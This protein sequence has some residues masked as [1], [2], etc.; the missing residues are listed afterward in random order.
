MIKARSFDKSGEVRGW[1]TALYYFA[2]HVRMLSFGHIN[3][4]VLY[5]FVGT[6]GHYINHENPAIR[7]RT[8]AVL[9][10]LIHSSRYAGDF[11]A[12]FEKN[13]RVF[14]EAACE[15]RD[16]LYVSSGRTPQELI[17]YFMD[18]VWADVRRG[19]ENEWEDGRSEI[20]LVRIESEMQSLFSRCKALPKEQVSERLALVISSYFHLLAFGFLDERLVYELAD[21]TPV[22]LSADMIDSGSGALGDLVR[23]ACI[24]KYDNNCGEAVINWWVVNAEKPFF[25]GRY[26][27]C[28][29]IE[30][31]P[32]VLRR[33]CQIVQ[34]EGT[35]FFEDLKSTH[36]SKVLRGNKVVFESEKD[37]S[38][39]FEL[40][41]GDRIALADKAH[42]WFGELRNVAY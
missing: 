11:R 12:S 17:S 36:G 15:L 13:N 29:I 28:D 21:E 24:I 16:G 10:R 4:K 41:L 38:S 3:H 1:H 19:F 6:N 22:S 2:E 20:N 42:F 30:S 40:Q 26:T 37:G 34:R 32:L 8:A 23:N 25:I 9:S 7:R 27:D 33:H 14:D 31:N 18:E 5:S 39:P 35:W